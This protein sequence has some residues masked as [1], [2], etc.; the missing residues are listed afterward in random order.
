MP[1]HN[2][3]C[4]RVF[5]RERPPHHLAGG[6]LEYLLER[7]EAPKL[8]LRC[9][10]HNEVKQVYWYVNDR[11][12]QAGQANEKVFFTPAAAGKVKISCTDDQGRNTDAWVT[13]RYV[14]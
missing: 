13:V 11:F 10:A 3:A 8:M 4:R 6:G 14:E 1:P 2:P 7:Q 5:L 12:L 9:N